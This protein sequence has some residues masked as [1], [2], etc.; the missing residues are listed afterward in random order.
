[1]GR[2]DVHRFNLCYRR[3]GSDF[4]KSTTLVTN[5]GS[6][7]RVA[8]WRKRR[9]SHDNLLEGSETKAQ[10]NPYPPRFA[11]RFATAVGKHH[12]NVSRLRHH[13]QSGWKA[14]WGVGANCKMH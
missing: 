12:F 5:C 7:Q 6:S 13:R 3:F 10:G 9:T 4:G 8:L 14:S 1:M 11:A 2:R